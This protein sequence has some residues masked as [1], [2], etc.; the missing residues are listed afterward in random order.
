MKQT[1][2][3]SAAGIYELLGEETP[4]QLALLSRE[5]YCDDHGLWG[6]TKKQSPMPGQ[7]NPEDPQK[8]WEQIARQAQQRKERSDREED[9]AA[10]MLKIE[11]NKQRRQRSYR[12]F[13][14]KFSAWQEQ[15]RCDPDEFDLNYYTYGLSTYGN[16][17]L[18]EPLETR[19]EYRIREFVIVVDSSYSTSGELIR[20]FLQETLHILLE[21]HAYSAGAKVHLIQCDDRVQEDRVITSSAEAR[22]VLGQFEI[23]GG[24]S[25][26]F[27]PAFTYVEEL[28][29]KGELRRLG[30]ML[31]FTDGNGTYPA[32]KPDYPCAFLYLSDYDEQAVPPWAIRRMLKGDNN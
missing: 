20:G 10:Q 9:A 14:M 3:L 5:F 15:L 22:Q 8:K 28:R 32:K 26:D 16:L 7:S 13:L 6:E 23:R 30:G 2:V 21:E 11:V 24:G 29:K 1:G 27:R 19:E 12:D 25:T 31:Y 18:I 4:E 17:P